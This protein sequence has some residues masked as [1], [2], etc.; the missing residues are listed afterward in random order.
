M[1]ETIYEELLTRVSNSDEAG[2]VQ[3][4]YRARLSA[5]K[6]FLSQTFLSK[7]IDGLK[8][9]GRVCS[10]CSEAMAGDSSRTTVAL[11]AAEVHARLMVTVREVVESLID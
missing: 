9:I 3:D 6:L 5:G 2:L 4:W 10:G 11:N 1:L 7:R 8:L